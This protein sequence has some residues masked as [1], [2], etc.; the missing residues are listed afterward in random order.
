MT[1]VGV[2]FGGISAERGVSLKQ[3][4]NEALR[5]G[6]DRPSGRRRAYRVPTFDLRAR[7]GV[8]LDK[9]LALSA[10]LEDREIVR[11]LARGK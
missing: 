3:V 2:L 6:L 4:V 8:N 10:E 9:A 1:R 11:K 7:P 5:A